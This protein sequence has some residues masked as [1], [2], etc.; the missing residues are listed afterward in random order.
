ME[1]LQVANGYLAEIIEA[2]VLRFTEEWHRLGDR[3]RPGGGYTE[4]WSDSGPSVDLQGIHL[5][6]TARLA[7]I[8]SDLDEC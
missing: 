2:D 4:M 1:R 8:M 7:R 5:S 3:H 6:A